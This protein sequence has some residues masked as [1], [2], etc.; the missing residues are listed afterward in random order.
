MKVINATRLMLALTIRDASKDTAKAV[1]KK[2][3]MD[4]I[5]STTDQGIGLAGIDSC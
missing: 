2:P 1:I 5:R 4:M 3:L